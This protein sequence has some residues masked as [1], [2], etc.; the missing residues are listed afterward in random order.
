[1]GMFPLLPPIFHRTAADEVPVLPSPSQSMTWHHI[2]RLAPLSLVPL[3]YLSALSSQHFLDAWRD[4]CPSRLA[5]VRL[6][7]YTVTLQ[8]CE[9]E[10]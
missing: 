4:L 5:Q 2:A 6:P 9:T 3:S 7:C 8:N 1:M 10:T